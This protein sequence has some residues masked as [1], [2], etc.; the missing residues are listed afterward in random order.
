MPANEIIIDAINLGGLADG[1]Y[2]GAKNSVAAMRNLDVHT[3]GGIIQLS[4][5]FTNKA[6]GSI[7]HSG[8]FTTIVSD[9]EGVTWYFDD[10]GKVVKRAGDGAYSNVAD[11]SPTTGDAGVS[12]AWQLGGFVYYS[13]GQSIGRFEVQALGAGYASKDDDWGTPTG[14]VLNR[15]MTEVNEILYISAGNIIDQIESGVLTT[16]VLQFPTKWDITA[17]GKFETDLLIGMNVDGTVDEARI[18]RWNTWSTDNSFTNDD[19]VEGSQINAF[20]PLDNAVIVSVGKRGKLFFFNGAVLK[21]FKT[22]PSNGSFDSQGE[23][24]RNASVLFM[25]QLLFGFSKVSGSDIPQ[26]IY[27]YGSHSEGYPLVLTMPHNIS[28]ENDTNVFVTAM[29]RKAET[30]FVA[31]KDETSGTVRGLD[32]LV[33]TR[34]ASGYFDT[35]VIN[36]ARNQIKDFE[37]DVFYRS[38]PSGTDIAIWASKDGGAFAEV[39]SIKDEERD[40]K[41][42]TIMTGDCSTLQIRAILTGA[43]ANS[44][45]VES[46]RISFD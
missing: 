46:L 23:V 17:L 19:F 41:H 31:W 8:D 28:T 5:G 4:R 35:R 37:V 21:P 27:S 13:M 20:L 36:V 42:T 45:E 7:T 16:N 33:S 43:G 15:S 18:V 9:S 22:V 26:G 10:N 29:A 6:T 30:L 39:E 44:P 32:E 34:H 12:D 38:L 11:V 1:K 14:T 25:G 3:E 40:T 24:W 2:Q